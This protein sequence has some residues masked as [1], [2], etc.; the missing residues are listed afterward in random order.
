MGGIESRDEGGERGGRTR[1]QGQANLV[2]STRELI[3]DVL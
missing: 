3:Y 2:L 1:G